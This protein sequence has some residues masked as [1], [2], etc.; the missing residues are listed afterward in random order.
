MPVGD[1]IVNRVEQDVERF[2]PY[3]PKIALSSLGS[4]AALMGA[5][6]LASEHA[7]LRLGISP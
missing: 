6:K 7:L 4:N 1:M 2:T 5:L 3:P